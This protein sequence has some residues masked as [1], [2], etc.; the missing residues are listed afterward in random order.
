MGWYYNPPPPQQ[1]RP[2]VIL[3]GTPG[4][5][6]PI[7]AL[8][9]AAIA[10]VMVSW[11]SAHDPAAYQQRQPKIAALQQGPIVNNPPVKSGYPVFYGDPQRPLRGLTWQY[12]TANAKGTFGDVTPPV[13]VSQPPTK[14]SYPVFY[15]DPQRPIRG[16]TWQYGTANATGAFS[17]YGYV[18]PPLPPPTTGPLGV[19]A[20]NAWPPVAWNAQRSSGIQPA[21]IVQPSTG[22]EPPG[23]GVGGAEAPD[24]QAYGYY[25]AWPTQR[26]GTI[27]GLV[28][29]PAIN[30]PIPSSRTLQQNVGGWPQ[31]TWGAQSA[32]RVAGFL[33]SPPATNAPP[34]YVNPQQN[35]NAWPQVSWLA[36]TFADCAGIIPL[37]SNPPGCVTG[38]AAAPD[39]A[40]YGYYDPWP[41]QRAQGVAGFLYVPPVISNV[42]PYTPLPYAVL[43]AWALA[44]TWPAQTFPDVQ[45][46][47]TIVYGSAPP[48]TSNAAMLALRS[49]WADPTWPAQT[50]PDVAPTIPPPVVNINLYPLAQPGIGISWALAP[51]WPAQTF[52]DTAP[53]GTLV[54]GTQPPPVSIAGMMAIRVTWADPT[55]PAQTFPDS[56]PIVLPP[57]VNLP[58]LQAPSQQAVM[59]ANWGQGATWGVQ[60]FPDSAGLVPPPPAQVPASP[61]QS[62]I[63]AAWQATTWGAQTAATLAALVPPPIPVVPP[64]PPPAALSIAW[65]QAPTWGAQRAAPGAAL[66]SLIYGQAPPPYSIVVPMSV[67]ILWSDPT[68]ATQY[69]TLQPQAGLAVPVRAGLTV[70][71]ITQEKTIGMVS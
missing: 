9:A 56:A 15:N 65:L 51:T 36:Q 66:A 3:S 30:N 21:G 4:Q 61:A 60:T 8:L 41:A 25:D 33:Y 43:T 16:L 46:L 42:I 54:Y 70:C 71:T 18:P 13:I 26:A 19:L 67:R 2:R 35:L 10:T 57:P 45:P 32:A 6:P 22:S 23:A 14:S 1:P 7:K 29:P 55:W 27:A 34:P 11:P 50:F 44:P 39:L 40:A 28:P 38:G 58:P 47:G 17:G 12:G 49:V 53:V 64:T 48:P 69:L 37:P 20:V 52:P 59:A 62:A 63:L 31:V 24:L 5:N 68:W